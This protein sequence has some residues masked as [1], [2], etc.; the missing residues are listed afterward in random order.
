MID[1]L[2]ERQPLEVLAAEFTERLRKGERPSME[3]YA[4]RCPELADKIRDLFPAVLMM[5]NLKRGRL[6]S[7]SIL[8]RAPLP[9]RLG[10]YRVVR[11][12]G[13]GGMGVVY[14]AVQE[15]LDRRVAVKV[16]AGAALLD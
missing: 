11:E 7:T 9:E 13:R 15:S 10:E 3:E 6:A 16:L 14:E 1:T 8:V 2:S 12:V 5:E 4:V